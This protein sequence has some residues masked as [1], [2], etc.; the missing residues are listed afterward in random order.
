MK[1][2]QIKNIY[3]E[4][5]KIQNDL[6]LKEGTVKQSG[7]DSDQLEKDVNAILGNTKQNKINEALAKIEKLS[8]K[9]NQMLISKD[10]LRKRHEFLNSLITNI[11]SQNIKDLEIDN[12]MKVCE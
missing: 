6:K 11:K 4:L 7:L 1:H 10:N 3:E 12:K 5:T 8:V 2:Q 9:F